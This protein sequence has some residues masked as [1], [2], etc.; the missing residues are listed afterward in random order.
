MRRRPCVE[1]RTTGGIH[2]HYVGL[3]ATWVMEPS[4]E[5]S[6]E[7]H[8]ISRERNQRSHSQTTVM[9]R[10]GMYTAGWLRWWRA[11]SD[12][13]DR[14]QRRTVS[15]KIWAE[16]VLVR[17]QSSVATVEAG[18][19]LDL[20]FF[21]TAR[22]SVPRHPLGYNVARLWER[23]WPPKTQGELRDLLAVAGMVSKSEDASR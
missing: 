19:T 18:G 12:V 14:T 1:R 4:G 2:C 3:R 17:R 20:G 9:S 10:L 22:K 11:V 7:S 6:H 23:L 16:Y 13:G 21:S 8:V 15:M 5:C